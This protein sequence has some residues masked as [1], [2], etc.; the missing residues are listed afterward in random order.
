MKRDIEKIL[1]N[2]DFAKGSNHK[3]E[4][5]AMLFNNNSAKIVKFPMNRELSEDELDM[6]SAAGLYEEKYKKKD[7]DNNPFTDD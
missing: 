5:R 2:A 1:K 6:V 3:E 7:N 4:L